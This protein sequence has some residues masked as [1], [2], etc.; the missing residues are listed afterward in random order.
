MRKLK[1][2]PVLWLFFFLFFV[3]CSCSL[4]AFSLYLDGDFQFQNAC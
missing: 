2:G 4:Y 1:K 3:V